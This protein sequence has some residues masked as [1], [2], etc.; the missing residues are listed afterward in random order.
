LWINLWI[1]AEVNFNFYTRP[2]MII[3]DQII[4]YTC[5][6]TWNLHRYGLAA[7]RVRG[8]EALALRGLVRGQQVVKLITPRFTPLLYIRQE[9]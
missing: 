5:R 7:L 8:R 1:R 4:Y 6:E 9:I 2:R 3:L